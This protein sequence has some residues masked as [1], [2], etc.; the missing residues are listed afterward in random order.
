M[1]AYPLQTARH[2]IAPRLRCRADGRAAPDTALHPSKRQISD[3]P[4]LRADPLA[5]Q[6][7]RI[8]PVRLEMSN[9]AVACG[10]AIRVRILLKIGILG[11]PLWTKARHHGMD[12]R[13]SDADPS[14]RGCKAADAAA[15]YY[16][17]EVSLICFWI[18]VRK[19]TL[20]QSGH[21]RPKIM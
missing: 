1:R 12:Y 21:L 20:G 18:R 14:L 17:P 11:D 16:L 9:E 8:I 4:P 19:P 2:K 13:A 6:T 15:L 7:P 5:S 3:T 10:I